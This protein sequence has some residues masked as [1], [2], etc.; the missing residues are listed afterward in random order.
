MILT[1][2]LADWSVEQLLQILRITEKTASMSVDTVG[3]SAVLYFVEGKMVDAKFDADTPVD[4]PQQR[5]VEAVAK[6]M[7]APDGKFDIGTEMSPS[8]GDPIPI[9][10]LMSA[11]AI[12]RSTEGELA[13]IGVLDAEALRL[14]RRS[15]GPL[16]I[17]PES[18]L[19]VAR[20]A[21][22]ITFREL[23][24]RLGR[25]GAIEVIRTLRDLG[26]LEMSVRKTPTGEEPAAPE[27]DARQFA[28]FLSDD[29]APEPAEAEGEPGSAE[30]GLVGEEPSPGDDEKLTAGEEDGDVYVRPRREMRAV[31]TPAE[32]T[33]VPGVL[34][35]I[36]TRFRDSD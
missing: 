10:D 8:A 19:A 28:D 16:L 6:L 23:E 32:T 17:A 22:S 29:G 26:V 21:G 30:E 27:P 5:M 12:W 1:G 2:Q 24:S 35:D 36:R 34:S 9:P 33:L 15:D 13:A 31:I 20:F 11:V 7:A 18:W 25:I 4:D 14:L 3:F